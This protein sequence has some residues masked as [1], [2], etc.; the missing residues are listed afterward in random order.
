MLVEVGTHYKSLT[1]GEI[2]KYMFVMMIC[3]ELTVEPVK[4][5]LRLVSH[6]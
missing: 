2:V 1:V 5:Q 6:K 3:H 4:Y